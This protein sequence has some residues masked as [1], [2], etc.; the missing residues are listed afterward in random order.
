M[1][2]LGLISLSQAGAVRLSS[3]RESFGMRQF[4]TNATSIAA[5]GKHTFP[6]GGRS[7]LR[8]D[9]E[10]VRSNAR[11]QALPGVVRFRRGL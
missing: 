5:R 2:G 11:L 4:I 9:A 3:V 8:G 7:A 1:F 6:G 10:G